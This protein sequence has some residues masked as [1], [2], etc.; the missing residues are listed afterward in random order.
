MSNE[1]YFKL[2]SDLARDLTNGEVSL[3]TFPEVVLRIRKLLEKEDVL[4][5]QVGSAVSADPVL[6]SRLLVFA[7]SAHHNPAGV[8]IESVDIAISRLGFALVKNTAVSLAIKQLA[9][10]EKH[11]D[12][13]PQMRG[14]WQRS[15]QLAAMASAIAADRNGLDKESAFLC[16]LLHDVGK[17][18][19]L[20]RAKEYPDLLADQ[21][22][23]EALL[24]DWH[25]KVGKSI[26]ES[27]DF[28]ED[29]TQ[30]LEPNEH[31]S[32]FSHEEA[33][34]VDVVYVGSMLLQHIAG[35]MDEESAAEIVAIP[36]F[37]RLG[38]DAS[39]IA[40]L[41][42]AYQ[43]KLGAVREALTA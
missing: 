15:M 25:P 16:G 41:H 7:N 27:W 5:A 17:I 18:Y 39:D 36:A 34:L 43:E 21:Q 20:T 26:V 28:P 31:M 35:D 14:I 37:V 32:E 4:I 40:P 42:A 8:R 3:P 19:I 33:T 2:V 9:L 24:A 12:V 30:T 38:I 1:A 29:V 22:Q 10:A 11:K 23:F 6:A 13:A